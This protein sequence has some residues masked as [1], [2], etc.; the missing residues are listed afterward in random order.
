[1]PALAPM[2]AWHRTGG[3]SMADPMMTLLYIYAY[4]RHRPQWAN[5]MLTAF[6][7]DTD[8]TVLTVMVPPEASFV[9]GF[10]ANEFSRHIKDPTIAE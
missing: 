6:A 5:D 4:M 8:M 1:M 9:G 10:S 3:K 7:C 2:I